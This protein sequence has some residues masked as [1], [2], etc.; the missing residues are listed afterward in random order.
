MGQVVHGV[1]Q[2]PALFGFIPDGGVCIAVIRRCDREEGA[3]EVTALIRTPADLNRAGGRQVLELPGQRW[4]HD[5]DSRLRLEQSHDLLLRDCP[6]AD[7]DAM[8]AAK[9]Q[10]NGVEC[11][12]P[13]LTLWW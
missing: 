7:N 11:H 4:A 12:V 5:C 9:V 10:K 13:R 8:P 1:Q 6:A 2:D 3:L